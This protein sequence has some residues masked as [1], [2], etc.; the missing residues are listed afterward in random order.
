MIFYLCEYMIFQYNGCGIFNVHYLHETENINDFVLTDS[1][2][3]LF[4]HDR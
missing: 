3:A 2:R 1:L 4:M